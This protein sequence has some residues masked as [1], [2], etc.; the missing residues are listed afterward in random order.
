MLA[1]LLALW[2]SQLR[3]QSEVIVNQ[4]VVSTA[5]VKDP[6]LI[7]FFLRSSL[8]PEDSVTTIQFV[9]VTRNGFGNDDVIICY[10]SGKYYQFFASDSAQR[11]MKRWEFTANKQLVVEDQDPNVLKNMKA[12]DNID[13]ATNWILAG[14]LQELNRNYKDLPIK[15]LFERDARGIIKFD[16]WGYNPRPGVLEWETPP[17]PPTVPETSYDMLH[18]MRID[19]LVYADSTTY[20]QIYIYHTVSDTVY[21]PVR[22]DFSQSAQADSLQYQPGLLPRPRKKQ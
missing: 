3:A 20:D 9:D 12:K 14:L 8:I 10:P 2:P 11:M 15:I 6:M 16:M 17:P 22:R 4:M 5:T 1:L 19:T 7:E 13:K 21:L 18:V